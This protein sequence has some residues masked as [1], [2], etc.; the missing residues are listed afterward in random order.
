[1]SFCYPSPF[2]GFEAARE[3]QFFLIGKAVCRDAN[4]AMSLTDREL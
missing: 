2:L 1:M 3:C 4:A